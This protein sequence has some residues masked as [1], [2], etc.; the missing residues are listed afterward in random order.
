[1]TSE[2]FEKLDPRE[3]RGV[4]GGLGY[5]QLQTANGL[6]NYDWLQRAAAKLRANL[7]VLPPVGPVPR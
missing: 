5:T 6:V 4:V 7:Q 2:R 1:M 3:M